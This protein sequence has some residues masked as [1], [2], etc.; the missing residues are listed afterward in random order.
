MTQ[1]LDPGMRLDKC[2]WC[3]EPDVPVFEDNGRCD[4]CDQHVIKCNICK[5]EQHR[6]D[7][8]R[9]LNEDPDT[10]EFYGSGYDA[11]GNPRVKAHLFRLFDLM[12]GGFAVDLAKA[13]RGRVFY[14]WLVAPIIGGGGRL[15]LNGMPS[16]EGVSDYFGWGDYMLQIGESEQAHEAAMGYGWLSSLYLR[17]TEKSNRTTLKW[18]AEYLKLAKSRKA[19]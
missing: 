2:V 17:K 14:T 19:A 11:R 18:I 15:E 6:D 1:Q 4:E 12:P 5:T 9:H 8:C 7:F 16:R 13:I 10:G 3:G